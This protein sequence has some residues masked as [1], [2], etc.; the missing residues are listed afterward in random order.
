MASETHASP[1]GEYE[2]RGELS[3]VVSLTLPRGGEC[4]ASNGG[5][6][7]YEKGIDWRLRVPGGGSGIA[8]RVLSGEGVA[9]TYITAQKDAARLCLASNDPGHIAAWDLA[10]GPVTTTRGSFLAAIGDVQ[11]TV[12]VARRAGAAFFGGAGLFLQT[13]RGQGIVFVHGAGDFID[14]RLHPG[15]A[16]LVSTGNLAAFGQ[17]ID[18]NIRGVGGC[19]KMIFSKEGLFMTELSG[20]GRV[21]LQT[22]KRRK[23]Q[24]QS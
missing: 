5:L 24:S 20:S 3:Q 23:S 10:D 9:L 19:L 13:V 2:I 14:Q 8:G 7:S 6:L 18:Y 4:W 1:W 21:L 16:V 11:I 15:D 12:T 17:G 22:L